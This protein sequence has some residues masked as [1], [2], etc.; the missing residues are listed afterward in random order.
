MTEEVSDASLAAG[1]GVC[2]YI[3]ATLLYFS[4][5]SNIQFRHWIFPLHNKMQFTLNSNKRV[6][7]YS[8]QVEKEDTQGRYYN[9][10]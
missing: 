3:P 4:L 7:N 1:F 6:S 8:L 10:F 5:L 9:P 2:I